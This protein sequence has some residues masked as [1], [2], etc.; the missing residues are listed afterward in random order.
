MACFL[1]VRLLFCLSYP[2]CPSSRAKSKE[3]L[4]KEALSA[5]P[6][7]QCNSGSVAESGLWLLPAQTPINR[8]GWWEGK[9]ALFQMPAARGIGQTSAQRLTPL[10]LSSPGG[11]SFYRHREGATCR[12]STASPAGRLEIGPRWS[13]QHYL[14]CFGYS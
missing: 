4:F 2:A 9:L 7:P 5:C 10:P 6:C 3:H 14:G 13:D 1:E 8:P 12:S 11:E